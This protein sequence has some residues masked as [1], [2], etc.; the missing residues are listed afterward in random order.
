MERIEEQLPA[1][2]ATRFDVDRGSRVHLVDRHGA[3]RTWSCPYTGP[4]W[5]T[6]DRFVADRVQLQ[7]LEQLLR[8][9]S[10]GKGTV[11]VLQC[12]EGG[13]GGADGKGAFTAEWAMCLI[14]AGPEETGPWTAGG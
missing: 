8:A 13:P 6:L 9:R 5:V 2:A 10:A 3:V 12:T 14:E 11:R 1:G 7:Q 4:K